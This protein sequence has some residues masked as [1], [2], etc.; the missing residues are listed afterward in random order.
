MCVKYSFLEL[1]ATVSFQE[2]EKNQPFY[3]ATTAPVTA[4]MTLYGSSLLM[5]FF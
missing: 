4:R 1:K 5:E 2:V 3:F